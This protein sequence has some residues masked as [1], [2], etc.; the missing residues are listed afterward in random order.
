MLSIE[1]VFEATLAKKLVI[2]ASVPVTLV[3]AFRL[4]TPNVLP[5]P[6]AIKSRISC[7]TNV[8]VSSIVMP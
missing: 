7:A 6:G 8:P 2:S 5:E 3:T 1:I 4:I